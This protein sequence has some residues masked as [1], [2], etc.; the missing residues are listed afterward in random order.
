[1]SLSL[2]AVEREI[3]RLWEEE[4]QRSHAPRIELLTLVA[5]VSERRL[6]ERAQKVVAEVVRTYPSR[7]IVVT[8][9]DGSEAKLTAEVA[10]HQVTP[11]G[12]VCGDA[13][14]VEAISGGRRWLPEN[15]DRL[16]LS[17][18]PMCLWWVGDIPDFDDLFDRSV[19]SSDLVIVNS[20]EMDLRDLE[21]LS[22]IVSR[23]R[24][25]YAVTDLTWSR[26]KSLQELIARFFDDES[27]CGYLS[28]IERIA[29]EFAPREAELDVASTQAAL[30][31]GWIA[32]ALSLRPEGVQWKRGA[33][34][35]EA[36]VGK[37][38]VRFD[39]RPRADVVSG[40]VLR[41]VI[42][43]GGA[44]FEVE[45]LE[46]PLVLRWSR[47]VPGSTTAPQTLRMSTLEEATLLIRCLGRP[48]RDALFER[49]L[50]TG[51]RFVRPVAPRFSTPPNRG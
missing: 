8:W 18:L 22:S 36:T 49:S 17:D 10:L 43:G 1:V 6:L 16:L 24:G 3:G 41:V 19:V 38:T 46:D 40:A 9:K 42:E 39:H 48:R 4:A 31:F 35:G 28:K 20:G 44:R 33:D 7:S 34:W 21:K 15:I 5:L 30:L 26:L 29:I 14:S 25:R 50:H 37:V 32:Q 23:S 47:D 13:I 2:D 51:S 45:R 27:A 12:A 11:G